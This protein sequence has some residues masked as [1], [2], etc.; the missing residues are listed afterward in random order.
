MVQLSAATSAQWAMVMAIGQ[1]RSRPGGPY[2]TAGL[3][4]ISGPSSDKVLHTQSKKELNQNQV[5]TYN[6]FAL[7]LSC[8]LIKIYKVRE[9]TGATLT[10]IKTTYLMIL[11]TYCI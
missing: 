7:V 10:H 6:T 2:M 1:D 5:G 4:K 8:I 3:K 9:N 11:Q